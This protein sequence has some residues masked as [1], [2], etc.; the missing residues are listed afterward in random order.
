M[1]IPGYGCV[2][3]ETVGHY[4]SYGFSGRLGPYFQLKLLIN[5][6]QFSTVEMS[7]LVFLV[8]Q[9][10]YPIVHFSFCFF[11]IFCAIAAVGKV[12]P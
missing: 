2:Y 6:L 7:L 11:L 4:M 9:V 8:Y 12:P 3:G 10:I 1:L 5:I